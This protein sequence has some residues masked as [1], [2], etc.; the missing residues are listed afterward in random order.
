[1]TSDLATFPQLRNTPELTER[2][3]EADKAVASGLW[4]AE[5]GNTHR[6][7]ASTWRRFQELAAA[8]YLGRLAADRIHKGRQFSIECPRELLRSN[9]TNSR[10]QP[11]SG[12][13]ADL[14]AFT[15]CLKHAYETILTYS[16][17]PSKPL[18]GARRTPF[19]KLPTVCCLRAMRSIRR[20]GGS[21]WGATPSG[22]MR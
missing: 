13:A 6:S 20:L 7:Y 1:M 22:S 14:T 19:S 3:R 16:S 11:F 9:L 21:W 5:A 10:P 18:K 4:D 12:N 8:G 17:R 15:G 2:D